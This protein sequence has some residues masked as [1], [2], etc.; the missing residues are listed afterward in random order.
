MSYYKLMKI[1]GKGS[2]KCSIW[3]VCELGQPMQVQGLN[4]QD[5][6]W[7]RLEPGGSIHI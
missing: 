6:R 2:I 3:T 5:T 4:S 7:E 1:K